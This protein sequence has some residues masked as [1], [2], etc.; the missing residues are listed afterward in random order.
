MARFEATLARASAQC[1]LLPAAQA[2]V[3]SQVCSVASFDA[4]A[5]ARAAREAGTLAIPFVKALTDK[6]TAVSPDAARHVH[7]GNAGWL[8]QRFAAPLWMTETEFLTAHAQYQ[9]LA[10]FG[11]DATADL[12]AVVDVVRT[13]YA[14]LPPLRKNC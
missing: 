4:K 6:V 3:I 2:D 14:S 10:G 9:T 11:S 7:F 13:T 5:L 1:G 12:F 8:T